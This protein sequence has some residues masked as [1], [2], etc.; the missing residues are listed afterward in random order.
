MSFDF[1]AAVQAP[2]RM[3]P[4]LRRLEPGARQLT[5]SAP[6]DQHLREKLA[7]LVAHAGQA[8]CEQPGFD[9]RPAL[10]AL[11]RH[12]AAEHPGCWSWDGHEATAQALGVAVSGETVR[13]L[14][15]AAQA[16]PLLHCL[17]QLP[18][19]WRLAGLLSLAFAEDFAVIDGQDTRI[20]WLAVALPSHWSPQDKVGRLFAQVH[21]PVADNALL[22]QAAQGLSRLVTGEQCWERFVWT[23]SPHGRLDGHPD[24]VPAGRWGGVSA[25][26]AWWRTERQTFIPV[27][28]VQQAVFTILVQV[29]PLAEAIDSPARAARLYDALAS[30]SADVLA[31]R[32]LTSMRGPLLAWLAARR[33]G[34]SSR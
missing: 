19:Q 10:H 23:I 7:V 2:M 17:A 6:G 9:A 31:Y 12:A 15:H 26:N 14:A 30:M 4:G 21:A 33:D 18:V 34:C 24:R 27:A 16:R 25:A 1:D 32:G 13:A 28:G 8:L 22:V 3:Q 29:Q 11:C 5:P 20:P